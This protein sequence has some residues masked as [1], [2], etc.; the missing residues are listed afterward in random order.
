MKTTTSLAL[1]LLVGGALSGHAVA[2]DYT[3]QAGHGAQ[4]GHPTHLALERLAELVAERTDGRMEIA[5]FPDR[6]LGEE[7]EMVEGLQFGT[8]DMTVVS[9]GPLGGF[10]PQINVLDL[11][12]L[13]EDR[14]HAY[15]VFDGEVGRALLD[16]FD[17][18]GIHA[19][20]I[21][22][23][24]WRHLTSNIAVDAPDDLDGLKIRTME[25]AIHIA[26]FQAL[27]AGP[28][29]M[30]WGEVYTS[31]DQGV[32]DAQENPITVIYTNSLWEVQDY[33]TLTGHVYGPHLVLISRQ[34][35]D[36]LPDDLRQ[37]LLDTVG[38]VTHYQREQSVAVESEQIELLRAEGMTINPVDTAAFRERML[39]VHEEYQDRFGAD[40]MDSIR[41]AA[42][43]S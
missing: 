42:D 37:V 29:P 14:D 8:V 41:R 13:F 40:L 43:G 3:I 17:D 19:A 30:V 33:T 32:I 15:A 9:T 31:L 28:V 26:A 7:R 18:I 4:R 2:Q 25:N 36:G 20:A 16:R 27:G 21:W 6:Q 11:P 22:E 5:V 35:L 23:N 1:A 39:A 12:F 38:E 34:T 10:V 24:G